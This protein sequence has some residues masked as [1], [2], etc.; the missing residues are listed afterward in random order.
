MCDIMRHPEFPIEFYNRKEIEYLL[1]LLPPKK[2][3]RNKRK[4]KKKAAQ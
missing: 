4:N 1:S 2:K 3:K